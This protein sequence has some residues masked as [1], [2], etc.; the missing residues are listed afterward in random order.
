MEAFA[1]PLPGLTL[2]TTGC[3]V[4][5]GN[6]PRLLPLSVV[7]YLPLAASSSGPHGS[8]CGSALPLAAKSMI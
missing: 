6:N 8:F 2:D 1:F 3:H 7:T 5:R 4:S